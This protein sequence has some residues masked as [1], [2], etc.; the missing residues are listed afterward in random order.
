MH[1]S[2]IIRIVGLAAIGVLA[3]GVTACGSSSKG[4]TPAFSSTAG[5]AV[6][7]STDTT[8][9]PAIQVPSCATKPAALLSKQIIAGKGPAAKPGD[10]VVVKYIG[11]GWDNKKEFDASW[12][13]GLG[14]FEVAPLGQAQVIDG[15]NEGLVGA[16]AGER[17]LLVIP[18][19]L[20]YGAGGYP[21]AIAPN[22]TLVFVVDV[23][24]VHPKAS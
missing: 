9:K 20:A 5:C 17:R 22:E 15:W 6:G 2:K 14:T 1:T 24:S 11:F 3:F 7:V 23:V 16:K 10:S 13:N 12:D 18:P 21:P 19:A 4:S 8:K